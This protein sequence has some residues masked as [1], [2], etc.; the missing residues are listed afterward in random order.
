MYSR[1]WRPDVQVQGVVRATLLLGAPASILWVD[2]SCLW[3]RECCSAP[4]S[5]P[6][7]CNRWQVHVALS[8]PA[9]ASPAV[10]SSPSVW[11]RCRMWTTTAPTA[12]PSWAPTSACRP[13]LGKLGAAFCKTS[14]LVLTQPAVPLWAHLWGS[15]GLSHLCVFLFWGGG[16]ISQK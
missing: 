11:M 1:A 3:V 16:N 13:W 7:S 12:R 2:L 6:G 9:G 8:V 10:A 14:W 5:P 15:W 4:F